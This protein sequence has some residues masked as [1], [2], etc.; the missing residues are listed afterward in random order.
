[1]PPDRGRLRPLPRYIYM[2]VTVASFCNFSAF[3][4]LGLITAALLYIPYSFALTWQMTAALVT[5]TLAGGMVGALGAG[6]IADRVGRRR[7]LL[8]GSTLLLLGGILFTVAPTLETLIAGRMLA[9][10]AIGIST[11][12]ASLLVVELAPVEKRGALSTIPYFFQ[13][14]GTIGP[15]LVGF[16]I[17]SV[18][19]RGRMAM[20]WRLM[21]ASGVLVSVVELCAAAVLLPE[22]PRWLLAHERTLE[23]LVIMERI[24]GRANHDRLVQDYR[25]T[26]AGTQET[27]HGRHATWGEMARQHKYRRPVLVGVALQLIRKLSGNA[28]ITFYLTLILVEAAGLGRSAALLVSL[29]IYIP[30]F[31]VVFGVFRLLDRVGRKMMLLVSCVG[32]AVAILPLAGVLTAFGPATG[33]MSPHEHH[34]FIVDFLSGGAV[35]GVRD[36]VSLAR[37]AVCVIVILSLFL[38]RCCYSAGLGPVPSIHTAESLPQPVRA[39]GLSLAL[40]FSWAAAAASTVV[41]PWALVALPSGCIYWVFFAVALVGTLFIACCVRETAHSLNDSTERQKS[42]DATPCSTVPLHQPRPIPP[43]ASFIRETD[44][45]GDMEEVSI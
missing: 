41:F 37:Q 1:M 38:Q 35:M 8:L 19:P 30:D 45:T 3:Y 13:F 40:F 26:L 44:A 17:V 15:L 10:V 11:N 12:L 29:L 34:R 6:P 32:L 33:A 22:S 25:E 7:T 18:L 39:K 5:G 21:G 43:S 9:G 16:V 42:R 14:V 31:A 4:S 2:V 27:G 28:A 20:A 24:Y 23:G 36:D